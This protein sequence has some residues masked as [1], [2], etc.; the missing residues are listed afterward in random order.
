MTTKEQ[1]ETLFEPAF[2]SS[3][4]IPKL[5]ELILTLA[6]QGKLTEQLPSDTPVET[7][8]A[9]IE[10]ERKA[11]IKAKKIRRQKKLLKIDSDKIPT[12]TIPN[13]WEWCRLPFIY[14]TIGSRANQIKASEYKE[15]GKFP[16]VSQGQERIS[17]Y[18]DDHE[19]LLEIKDAVVVFGDH[20]KSI[21]YI[22][23]SFIIGADGVQVLKPHRNIHPKF[24]YYLI[25][26]CEIEDRGY[27]RHFGKLNENIIALPPKEEQQRI[28][29]KLDQLMAYCDQLE[30]DLADKSD[31]HERLIHSTEH[32]LLNA[33]SAQEKITT[34]QFIEHHFESLYQTESAVERLRGTLL[35][36]A[37]MGKLLPQD[38]SDEPASKLLAKISEEKEQLI[39]EGK[40]RRQR[41]LPKIT[42]E[43][44]PFEIPESWEWI[45]LGDIAEYVQRGRSPKYSDI[46]QIPVISQ[47]CIQWSQ[48]DINSARYIDPD[49]LENYQEERFI[50]EGD[51]LWNSTGTGTLGRIR[52]YMNEFASF[53]KIVADSH[54]T[55][56]RFLLME[57]QYLLNYL[58]SP[59]IQYGIED[60]AAGSTNQIELNLGIILNVLLPIPPI[61]EQKRIV[62]KLDQLMEFCDQL[63]TK[64]KQRTQVSGE[65]TDSL[66][67]TVA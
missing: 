63:E 32:H 67:A 38:P 39:E 52:I 37:V 23:F 41:A 55:V 62:E 21:K 26:N 54:V 15:N 10:K 45:R 31:L 8:L 50:R 46:K 57:N 51:L 4:G 27:A 9:E 58:K 24:L 3:I 44:I 16:V 33:E 2:I 61:E 6:M 17:G 29:E 42:P 65:L 49:S 64:I 48:L 60:R 5:R 20:T 11:L 12:Y 43:E 59:I 47:R 28:V 7:L 30:Q 22:N 53:E 25:H 36:L 18:F 19:K 66:V 14:Y 1:L 35:Q 56:V 34:W 40:I 13:S